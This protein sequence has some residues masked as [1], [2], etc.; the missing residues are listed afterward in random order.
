M[1]TQVNL[2]YS[3][4]Y[5]WYWIFNSIWKISL[6]YKAFRFYLSICECLWFVCGLV[7]LCAHVFFLKKLENLFS[8]ES[9]LKYSDFEYWKF[10][11]RLLNIH[12]VNIVF[13]SEWCSKPIYRSC[14][15]A[16]GFPVYLLVTEMLYSRWNTGNRRTFFAVLGEKFPR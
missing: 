10:L 5:I 6:R 12:V 14:L 3:N 13:P 7:A 15:N 2:F 4:E 16:Y 9:F 11:K 1:T 8:T